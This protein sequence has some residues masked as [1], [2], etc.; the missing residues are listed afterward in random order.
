MD[1][2]IGPAAWR[3]LEKKE[4][5]D[6]GPLVVWFGG[7]C[8][9][10]KHATLHPFQEILRIVHRN[11]GTLEVVFGTETDI[12]QSAGLCRMHP[13]E[14]PWSGPG[15]LG[16]SP[17]E[18]VRPSMRPSTTKPSATGKAGAFAR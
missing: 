8:I 11:E 18:I 10:L 9:S 3:S 7:D 1:S 2:C 14:T 12:T 4:L 5:S 13:T 6:E 15:R 17:R 16:R